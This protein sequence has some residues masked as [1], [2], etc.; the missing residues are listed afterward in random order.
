[1][2]VLSISSSILALAALALSSLALASAISTLE[3]NSRS[4]RFCLASSSS[5][6]WAISEVAS[7]RRELRSRMSSSM[8]GAFSSTGLPRSTAMLTTA[9]SVSARR[10]TTLLG[11]V[12]ALTVISRVTSEER[13]CSTRTRIGLPSLTLSWFSP[14]N[15]TGLLPRPLSIHSV[16]VT[17]TPTAMRIDLR[18]F[19]FIWKVSLDPSVGGVNYHSITSPKRAD[20]GL[21]H[22]D[23]KIKINGKLISEVVVLQRQ[24]IVFILEN[25]NHSLKIIPLLAGNAQFVALYGHLHLHFLFFDLLD[26][27]ARCF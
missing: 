9:P 4:R 10:L 22:S 24:S 27:L 25:S 17:A 15:S 12:L 2:V 8:I 6:R 5:S 23:Y 21:I 16:T 19:V 11:S 14:L 18:L 7:L 3:A 13:T 20:S 26:Y 1:M